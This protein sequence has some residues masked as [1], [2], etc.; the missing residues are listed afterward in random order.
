MAGAASTLE[1]PLPGD[2][3]EDLDP[4]E[5]LGR[6]AYGVVFRARQ[7]SRD[8]DVIV[9]LVRFSEASDP[10]ARERLQSE[11]RILETARHPH[12]CQLLEHGFGEDHAFLLFPDEGSRTLQDEIRERN[13][14]GGAPDPARAE[15]LLDQCLD[16]LG[17]I[18][19]HGFIHRD[20]KP[21]NLV[22]TGDDRLQII[23]FGLI[24]ELGSIEDVTGSGVV[25]G[26]LEYMAP[27]QMNG[28]EPDPRDDLYSA[29]VVFYEYLT[30]ENPFRGGDRLKT[31]ELHCYHRPPP[32]EKVVAG[33]PEHL[34]SLVTRLITKSRLARPA[35]AAEARR[36]LAERR[37]RPEF[38]VGPTEAVDRSDL[39]GG[40][41]LEPPL[42]APAPPEDGPRRG[43]A[44]LFL[45]VCAL[46]ALLLAATAPAPAPPPPPDTWVPK[47][48]GERTRRDRAREALG[49]A[50][51]VALAPSGLDA[52]P[53][54]GDAFDPLE[55]EAR[56]RSLPVVDTF[57]DWMI[58][59][60]HPE[61][62][63]PGEREE[64]RRLG[65]LM[66]ARGYESPFEP[67]L[68]WRP[69]DAGVIE[70]VRG[71]VDVSPHAVGVLR[72][73][74]VTAWRAMRDAARPRERFAAETRAILRGEYPPGIPVTIPNTFSS[75]GLLLPEVQAKD[76]GRWALPRIFGAGAASRRDAIA[77]LGHTTRLF[78]K[79]LYAVARASAHAG[80]EGER[81]ALLGAPWLQANAHLGTWALE[82][83][84]VRALTG[85][86]PLTAAAATIQALASN[87]ARAA[88]NIRPD[89]QPP[90]PRE[91]KRIYLAYRAAL[92]GPFG[93]DLARARFELVW[94]RLP[95]LLARNHAVD[96]L[97]A[98][99][100]ASGPGFQALP[101]RRRERL[102]GWIRKEIERFAGD[103][104]RL[105]R[106]VASY[107]ARPSRQSSRPNS[108]SLR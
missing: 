92:R 108:E 101:P 43:P 29:G 71:G 73:D 85:G 3:R 98:A 42:P 15:R 79:A 1:D 16:G 39:E 87:H 47:P 103:D 80:E 107:P 50:L 99:L 21:S 36:H 4:G 34:A 93:G 74:L 33:V 20:L 97:E 90:D 48:T 69:R 18:H 8:R 44:L 6:G 88:A 31:V 68:S 54:A 70:E 49:P 63:P 25:V 62:L 86:P 66:E 52:L 67:F 14:A 9:K 76:P 57:L 59:G 12:V 84:P 13:E 78:E 28:E 7:R 82:R 77:W 105:R 96:D 104:A 53:P 40:E 37:T 2:L 65:S 75:L 102:Q 26:T 23:D 41:A 106:L 56:V 55:W 27:D 11:V 91:L 81:A 94:E 95:K 83:L 46:L 30:G 35:D 45:V 32:V 89:G 24:R 17:S 100:E 19:G 61:A 51:R 60:G 72:G 64:L 10:H 58:E 22:L 5:V 38:D